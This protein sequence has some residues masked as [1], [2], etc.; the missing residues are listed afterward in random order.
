M[1]RFFD[2]LNAG[3]E[4]NKRAS[5]TTSGVRKILVESTNSAYQR[6]QLLRVSDVQR[7]SDVAVLKSAEKRGKMAETRRLVKICDSQRNSDDSSET[8]PKRQVNTEKKQYATA[9][10]RNN[11][12]GTGRLVKISDVHRDD[13]KKISDVQDIAPKTTSNNNSGQTVIQC[14]K[15]QNYIDVT[16]TAQQKQK[17]PR[18]EKDVIEELESALD[19]LHKSTENLQKPPPDLILPP[20]VEAK[21]ILESFKKEVSPYNTFTLPKSVE[22][23][24]VFR[25]TF[26][27]FPEVRESFRMVAKEVK[28]RI[29]SV[30]MRRKIKR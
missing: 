4:P 12:A 7:K 5:L 9:V 6:K 8:G 20:D 29:S 18:F 3:G 2:S 10:Y 13:L 22:A 28:N 15:L 25:P 19:L 26:Q 16:V 14:V 24:D 1:V 30:K 23:S 17:S 27:M 21:H 11:L